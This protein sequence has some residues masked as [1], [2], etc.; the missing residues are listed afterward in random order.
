MPILSGVHPTVIRQLRQG[1]ETAFR[2]VYD[3]LHKPVYRMVFSLL[4]NREQSEEIVQE[5][6]V[7]LWVNR[8]KLNDHQPLTPY[9]YLAARRMTIDAFRKAAAENGLKDRLF[10]PAAGF[11]N[12]TE[13]RVLEAD[14][15]RLV[16]KAVQELPPQ[17]QI[18]FSMS[19]V[20]GLSHSEIAERLHISRNTVKNHLVGAL[21]TLRSHFSKHD[22]HYGYFLFFLLLR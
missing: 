4:K 19:R 13:E 1:S 5:A 20:E 11:S 3:Q 7:S 12:A 2:A 17:Q 10:S 9:L 15:E 8:A 14:L 16:E 6:F 22:I 21:K 18:V